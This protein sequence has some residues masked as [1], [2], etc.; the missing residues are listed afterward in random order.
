VD[1][2]QDGKTKIVVGLGNPGLEYARSRHNVGFM[3]VETLVGRWGLGPGKRAFSGLLR[4][5]RV[6]APT[7]SPSQPRRAMLFEPHTYMN[8]S[9]RA[10]RELTS[11]YKTSVEDV[12]VILDDLALPRGRLRVRPGGSPG[13]HNGL[14]DVLAALG[15]PEVPRLRIGI[16]PPPDYMNATDFVLGRFEQEELMI[17]ERAIPLAAEAAEDWLFHSLAHVME[18]YNGISLERKEPDESEQEHV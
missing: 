13:G 7:G 2:G 1:S 11:F 6:S 12:L 16:G 18:K 10:V 5:G 4:D 14:A 8:C 17:M 15:T 3:V 9:G